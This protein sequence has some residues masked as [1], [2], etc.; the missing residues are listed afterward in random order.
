MEL[1]C[2]FEYEYSDA[3]Q[4]AIKNNWLCNLTGIPGCWFPMDLLQEHNI[5]QLKKMSIRRD[6]QWGGTFFK[7]IIAYNIRGFLQVIESMK[8]AVKLAP[9]GGAHR[10]KVKKAVM[11]ELADTMK[12]RELHK[13][14]VGRTSEHKAQDNFEQ[15]YITLADGAKIKEFIHRTLLDAGNVNGD[16][17]EDEDAPQEMDDEPSSEL[18]MPNT[19]MGGVLVLGDDDDGSEELGEEDA[20]MD[21]DGETDEME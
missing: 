13:L 1:A 15:G 6:A 19:V 14:R 10:R 17:D 9:K 7:E 3:L 2:N 11:K 5:K 12:E 18:P 20:D 4:E 8:S 21:M 16:N